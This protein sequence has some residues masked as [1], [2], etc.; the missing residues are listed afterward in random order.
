[1]M[2]K[3]I[4]TK[5]DKMPGEQDYAGLEFKN[6]YLLEKVSICFFW[7]LNDISSSFSSQRK[8]KRVDRAL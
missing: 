5:V 6:H 4:F 1:M 7:K 8:N 2:D 3:S